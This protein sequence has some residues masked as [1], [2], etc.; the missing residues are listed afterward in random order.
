MAQCVLWFTKGHRCITSKWEFQKE[1][2]K[3]APA[4][5]IIHR[6][7]HEYRT[8]DNHAHPGE[9]GRPKVG[10]ETKDRIGTMFLAVLTLLS[11]N[12]AITISIYHTIWRFQ[13]ED[14]RLFSY[15]LQFTIRN[16]AL[17]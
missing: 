17:G 16:K 2:R 9:N 14:L 6:L 15:K 8:R 10:R 12:S 3:P 5:F 11:S 7:F 13:K 4:C 1:Y